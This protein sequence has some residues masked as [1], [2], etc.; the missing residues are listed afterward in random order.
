MLSPS[1]LKPAT[2][3]TTHKPGPLTISKTSSPAASPQRLQS[4]SSGSSSSA[5]AAATA[6]RQRED[7]SLSPGGRPDR[8]R[9]SPPGKLARQGAHAQHPGEAGAAAGDAGVYFH[10]FS[11]GGAAATAETQ[12][13]SVQALEPTRNAGA[14]TVPERSS[15]EAA[16]AHE[17]L[18]QQIAERTGTSTAGSLSP[19]RK[20]SGAVTDSSSELLQSLNSSLAAKFQNMLDSK[21]E[22]Q[23]R[24]RTKYAAKQEQHEAFQAE[25]EAAF[26]HSHPAARFNAPAHVGFAEPK[27]SG[28][29]V[30]AS[31]AAARRYVVGSSSEGSVA[32]GA[33]CGVGCY[34][35]LLPGSTLFCQRWVC[36]WHDE[37]FL[38]WDGI[39]CAD[40]LHIVSTK[41]KR[42]Q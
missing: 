27:R 19:S 25:N 22:K 30:T 31:S 6:P 37:H 4:N 24:A 36:A 38:P 33:E 2:V 42:P 3:T 20:N 1:V 39:I 32:G 21:K 29:V 8:K 26:C 41:A 12:Q 23:A 13:M 10:A 18:K 28:A 5:L 7:G 34:T 16:H 14:K 40:H 9:L 15:G 17:Q 35:V 11:H